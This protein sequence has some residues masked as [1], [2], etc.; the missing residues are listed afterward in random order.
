MNELPI[1]SCSGSLRARGAAL[2][3]SL[4]LLVVIT[5]VGLASIRGTSIQEH[6]SANMYDR[7]LAFQ[8]A[9]TAARTVEQ[10]VTPPS[11]L[12]SFDASCTNGFCNEPHGPSAWNRI[13]DPNFTGWQTDTSPLGALVSD[14]SDPEYFVEDMGE[15]PVIPGCEQVVPVQPKC[16]ARHFHIYSRFAA[17]GRANVVLQTKFRRQ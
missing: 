8:A 14:T 7:E 6:M 5:V 4:I 2:A 13:Q 16:Y 11:P 9:E 10:L 3:V 12:P 1:F 17:T 15:Q